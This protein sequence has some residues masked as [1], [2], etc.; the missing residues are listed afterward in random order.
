VLALAEYE[1]SAIFVKSPWQH[2][3]LGENAALD[4]EA[5]HGCA[6]L[7]AHGAGAGVGCVQCHSGDF[8]IDERVHAI[9]FL[10][11]GPGFAGDGIDTGRQRVT[12]AAADRMAFVF[13][14]C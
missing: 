12:G 14:R 10:Q 11:S 7:P 1:R 2:Y 8:F 5:K 6:G 4:D 13:P 9:G 3:V